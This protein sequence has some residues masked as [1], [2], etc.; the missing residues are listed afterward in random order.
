MLKKGYVQV[1]TGGGKGKTSAA[2]GLILRAVSADLK[3]YC[4]QFL[5]KN[6]TGEV[7]ALESFSDQVT[8]VQS[9][10]KRAVGSPFSEEDQE[11]AVEDF[12]TA[13]DKVLS[14]AYD[15]VVF[16]EINILLHS[17]LIDV[18]E[19]LKMIED[20]PEHTELV[21]TGRYAPNALIREADLVTEMRLVKHYY[22]S[23]VMA[24]EGIER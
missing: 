2:F 16:D 8:I 7:R 9:G 17:N 23:G 4:V 18:G 5:K 12:R 1:Y 10:R 24:R 6:A 14:G 19:V 11:I 15:M 22:R 3:V 13:R 21:L 20:K